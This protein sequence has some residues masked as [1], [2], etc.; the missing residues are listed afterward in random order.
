MTEWNPAGY[1]RIAQLQQAMAEEVL[2]HLAFDGGERVLDVGCGQGRITA[3]VAT[4]VVRGSVLGVDASRDMVAYAQRH[5]SGP[6]H[7]NLSFAVADA[8]DLSAHRDF[9]RLISFNALHWIPEQAAVL[10]SLRNTLRPRGQAHLRFV[11]SGPRSSLEDVL[12]QVAH[13]PRWATAFT[14]TNPPY[15]HPEPTEY[16]RLAEAAGFKVLSMDRTDHCWDFETDAAFEAFAR[17]TFVEWTRRLPES[18]HLAFIREVLESYRPV[19]RERPGDDHCFRFY[20]LDAVL[21]AEGA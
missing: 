16:A 19:S 20:Q 1:D 15:V 9:D 17:V 2:R 14:G 12:E 11:P 3:A 8:R 10:R 7:P 5:H 21:E 13:R 4:R 18:D 6:N